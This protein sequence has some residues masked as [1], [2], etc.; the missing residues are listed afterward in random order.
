MPCLSQP[1]LRRLLTLATL[2]LLS[3][4]LALAQNNA[5]PPSSSSARPPAYSLVHSASYDK[6]AFTNWYSLAQVNPSGK[7][8]VVTHENPKHRHTCH[9]QSFSIDQLICS[10]HAG[11]T[12]RTQDI[13][14]LIVPGNYISQH[15]SL[16]IG[17]AALGAAIWGTIILA[18]VCPLCA[19][20]TAFGAFSAF[21]FSATT[22]MCDNVPDRLLYLTPGQSLQVKLRI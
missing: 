10:D 12:Y 16:A 19:A 15:V 11:T 4:T 13:A 22:L 14:A 2:T 7:L 18:P 5:Q 8:F 1:T 17:N 21:G 6:P 3:A 9:V 20:A